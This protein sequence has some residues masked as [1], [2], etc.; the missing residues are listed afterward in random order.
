MMRC[1]QLA[2]NGLGSTYPNPMVGCVI[3]HN[4]KIIA[5]GWHVKAGTAH[6]EV[7]AIEKV[8]HRD[9]LN[10]AILYVSLEPCSH[11]GKTPPCADL[12]I[13][14]GIKKVVIGSTDPN[15]KVAGRGIQK[16]IEAGCDVTVGVLNEACE[17]LNK[18]FFTYHQ[19][20]RPF[21]LLKWA[22][23]NDGFI[24]P[25]EVV[26]INKK[27]PV[28]ITNEYSRQWVHKLRA[29]EQAILV[30]TN[31]VVTDNPSLTVRDWKGSSPIRFVIDRVLK[32]ART[33]SVFDGTVETVVI[34]EKEVPLDEL[35]NYETVDFSENLPIQI[36]D[37]LYKRSIQSVI[38]E[39]GAKTLQQFIDAG[40]WDE[41]YVF[42][43]NS[44]FKTGVEAPKFS[45]NLI[46][47]VSLKE[48]ILRHFKNQSE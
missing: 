41:A 29:E 30:G 6:A 46:S 5:E 17:G 22:Q 37:V 10:K 7:V 33:A 21:I 32:I 36:C 39:G 15:P 24:A 34:T 19:M 9:H 47:E 23:T 8:S 14:S 48:D 43:G 28:W 2:K 40:L 38:I 11:F 44:E 25:D 4:K 20:K 35:A 18:R 26:R 12:I 1:I 3:V 27:E 16:L 13:S 45:G 42:T 31:T